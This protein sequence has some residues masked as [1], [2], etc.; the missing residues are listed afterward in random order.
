MAV[1]SLK[2]GIVVLN[3]NTYD[4]TRECLLSLRQATYPNR[5]VILVDNAS[6]DGSGH[7]LHLDFPE[8]SFIANPTNLGFARGANV[9]IRYALARGSD[10]ILLLNSDSLVE[11]GFLEPAVELAERH[12][13][14]G[15][16]SGK[17]YLKDRPG[18]LWYAGGHVSVIRGQVKVFGWHE[19]DDGRFDRVREI[20]FATG[21]LLLIKRVVLER[22]GLLPEEYFFG[23]EEWDYSV[24]VRRAGYRLYY[25]PQFVTYHR[26]DGSHRN[27]E[28]K[29]LYNG[30]RNR[31]IFQEKFLPAPAFHIWKSAFVIYHK[32]LARKRLAHLGDTVYRDS[33][34][35]LQAAI[36]DH[37]RAKPHIVTEQA[38][39][40]F[41]R[42]LA[43]DYASD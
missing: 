27:L 26:S 23:T 41:E 34:R 31:L 37:D 22:V 25:V 7:Q 19:R 15:L 9:G 35:A 2:V 38:L 29:Y 18:Y 6:A 28:A 17:I 39:V 36:R 43:D 1:G 8:C 40:D 11:P 24:T 16:V 4:E 30:Y 21:A 42:D 12:A 10:Y 20:G 33:W 3:W 14:V 32:Y 13:T 5:E